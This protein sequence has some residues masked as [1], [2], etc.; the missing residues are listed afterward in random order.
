MSPRECQRRTHHTTTR[1]ATV[2][3][4]LGQANPSLVFLA[5]DIRLARRPLRIERIEF[6]L[7][8]LFRRLA[9]VNSAANRLL[10]RLLLFA[11]Q[12]YFSS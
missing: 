1:E 4:D 12:S 11:V 9:G 8:P 6:L 5:C 10:E 7:K 2:I 3:V